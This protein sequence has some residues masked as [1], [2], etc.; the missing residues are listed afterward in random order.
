MENGSLFGADNG[1]TI[2]EYGVEEGKKSPLNC[3]AVAFWKTAADTPAE[4]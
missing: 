4:Q 1:Q 2:S 3:K